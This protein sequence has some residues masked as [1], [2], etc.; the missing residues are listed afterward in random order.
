MSKLSSNK[1]IF[2]TKNFPPQIWGIEKYSLEICNNH[3]TSK[4]FVLVKAWQRNNFLFSKSRIFPFNIF[5]FLSEVFRLFIFFFRVLF[6]FLYYFWRIDLV[7]WADASLSWLVYFLGKI[8]GSKTKITAHALD[9]V[10]NNHLYQRFMPFFWRNMDIIICLN[11]SLRSFLLN[12]WIDYSKIFLEPHKLSI[13]N[14][15]DISEEKTQE[16]KRLYAIPDDK[17]ILLSIGRFVEKKG[18]HWFLEEILP[19]ISQTHFF[20]ILI[21]DGP[22]KSCYQNIISSKHLNNVFMPWIISDE[23]TKAFFFTIADHFIVPTVKTDNDREWFPLVLLES[24]YFH[25]S[26]L[27]SSDI[28]LLDSTSSMKNITYLDNKETWI[29]FLKKYENNKKQN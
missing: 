1:I 5:Y 3:S 9:V 24:S 23:Q 17:I 11:N 27:V 26:T 7:W 29:S 8:T 4:N 19:Q 6:V 15:P 14:F 22:F 13:I 16:L 25:L 21:G 20:Y 12:K 2:L 18:F 10:W 28:D